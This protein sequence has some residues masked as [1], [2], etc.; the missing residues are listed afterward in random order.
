MS[1]AREAAL[2]AILIAGLHPQGRGLGVA[3]LASRMLCVRMALVRAP[4]AR[5]M[6]KGERRVP[7]SLVAGDW[8][9]EC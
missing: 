7:A 6:Q 4:T 8:A 5:L 9:C 3:A 1:G 2:I